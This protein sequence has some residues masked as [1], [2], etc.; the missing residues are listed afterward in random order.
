MDLSESEIKKL[1][2]PPSN[3]PK[4]IWTLDDN[5]LDEHIPLDNGYHKTHPSTDL[6][7]LDR[8]PLELLTDILL[9]V[10][11]QALTGFR[12]VNQRAMQ[13]VDSVPQ[14]DAIVEHAPNSLR[15]LLTV[16]KGRNVNCLELYDKMCTFKCETCGEFGGF[17]YLITLRRA[18]IECFRMS[19]DCFSLITSEARRGVGRSRTKTDFPAVDQIFAPPGCY[20]PD[21]RNFRHRTRL[22]DYNSLL[23]VQL[24]KSRDNEFE[25]A[26]LL[27]AVQGARDV[28]RYRTLR[29]PLP[30]L[31]MRTTILTTGFCRQPERYM[32]IIRFSYLDTHTKKAESGFRC[33]GCINVPRHY[34]WRDPDPFEREHH[35]E[36]ARVN[37]MFNWATFREHRETCPN[38]GC[39]RKPSTF[40]ALEKGECTKVLEET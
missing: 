26:E 15:A 19:A 2:T 4:K 30:Q 24:D 6:G 1:T 8:L 28:W 32:A 14:Y 11:L 17:L 31:H 33:K 29:G 40:Y 37:R 10:D 12:R 35:Q 39:K 16:N 21:I 9:Q 20:S 5:D 3:Y 25:T 7:I 38:L 34:G 18:C 27:N 23:K 13:V 36:W 22:Y